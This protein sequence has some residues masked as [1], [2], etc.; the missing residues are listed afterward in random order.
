M[1]NATFVRPNPDGGFFAPLCV[2]AGESAYWLPQNNT[3]AAALGVPFMGIESVISPGIFVGDRLSLSLV[4]VESPSGS[5]AYSLWKD[6][7]PP[8]FSL[9]SCDGVTAS[10]TLQLPIGHDHFNH[11]FSHEPGEW[12]V[13][14]R[15]AGTLVGGGSSS[16]TTFEVHFLTR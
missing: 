14:Y 9:S 16:S 10:D 13:T 2:D 12:T 7:F 3:D 8:S 11:G 6:G 4:N 1:T 15:I 5:G